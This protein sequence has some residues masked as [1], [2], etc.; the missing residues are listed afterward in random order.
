MRRKGW[1]FIFWS[2]IFLIFW[3]ERSNKNV[4]IYGRIRKRGM[5]KMRKENMHLLSAILKNIIFIILTY[6]MTIL[7]YGT[8][9]LK[10]LHLMLSR[11]ENGGAEN[12]A[13][14]RGHSVYKNGGRGLG[15]ILLMVTPSWIQVELGIV[16]RLSFP[17]VD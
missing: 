10:T 5:I 8:R 15:S 3:N 1:D 7:Y 6:S 17:M 14:I 2:K 12:S 4:L 11:M 13:P 9:W 16:Y